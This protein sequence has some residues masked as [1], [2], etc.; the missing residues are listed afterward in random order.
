MKASHLTFFCAAGLLSAA[1][2]QA[3]TATDLQPPFRVEADGKVIETE[4]GNAVPCVMDFDKDGTWDLLAGQFKEGKVRVFRNVGTKTAP[5]F[6]AGVWLK[7]GGADA[8]VPA[9]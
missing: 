6:A 5:K 4:G 8:R 1:S 2:A 7:A 3:A 9:G